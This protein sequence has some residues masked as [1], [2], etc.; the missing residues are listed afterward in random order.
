MDITEPTPSG[1]TVSRERIVTRL[2]VIGYFTA[3]A[4][5]MV[6][7]VSALGWLTLKL[8]MWLIA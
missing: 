8:A 2:L 6:G 3:V 5:A 7:W 1:S 4:I